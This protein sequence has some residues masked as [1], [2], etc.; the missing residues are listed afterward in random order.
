M[1]PKEPQ[2][3]DL[4]TFAGSENAK[5]RSPQANRVRGTIS[6]ATIRVQ[7]ENGERL[8][9]SKDLLESMTIW[10]VRPFP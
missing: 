6:P 5:K 8:E 1:P 3:Y 10:D 9:L 4:A 2:E 7:L